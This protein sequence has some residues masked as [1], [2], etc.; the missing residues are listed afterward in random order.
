MKYLLTGGTGF[1]GSAV[2]RSLAAGDCEIVV[3]SRTPFEPRRIGSAT[4]RYAA[5]DARTAGPWC[6]EIETTDAVINLAG[7]SLFSSR[8]TETV[9]RDLVASRVD[10]TSV[11]VRAMNAAAHKP[12]V[13]ISASAVGYYGDRADAIVTEAAPKGRGFLAE[14]AAQWEAAAAAAGSSGIRV[15]MPRIAIA[16]ERDGGALRKMAL[17]FYFFAGGYLGSGTQPLSWI[18]LDDLVRAIVFP[19][20][21]ASFAG[22]YNCSAPGLVTMKQFCAALGRA[23]H[24]PSWTFVPSFL[25]KA[26]LGEASEM[27][28]TGQ[29]V[30]PEKLLAAGFQ[31]HHETLDNALHSIYHT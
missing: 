23:L 24:R 1:I 16:L 10:S 5:W 11:L 26:V 19:I 7:K 4:V 14:L 18:H 25:L 12:S 22:A 27:L 28:L 15:A 30:V 20:G 21:H 9:K 13:F 3:L 8:W 17:P 2:I 6:D 31:F 29:K